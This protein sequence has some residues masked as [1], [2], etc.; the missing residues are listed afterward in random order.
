M[1]ILQTDFQKNTSN[2]PTMLDFLTVINIRGTN[3][4]NDKKNLYKT[5]YD[6]KVGEL[7]VIEYIQT[8]GNPNWIVLRNIWLNH[9]GNSECDLIL[10]T[11]YTIYVIEIK[12]YAGKFTYKNG[13]CYFNENETT[14]NP[15]EQVRKN[16]VNLQNILKQIY[17]NLDIQAVT[18]FAGN[19]NDVEIQSEL[20]DIKVII[21]TQIRSFILQIKNS[22][23]NKIDTLNPQKI[24]QTLNK[25]EISNPFMLDPLT[26]DEMNE[27]RGGIYCANCNNYNVEFSRLF[28]HCKCGLT[29]S[30]E[31]AIIRTIC[32]FGVLTYKRD[33]YRKD[34]IQFVGNKTSES[35]IRRVI[36]KHF[37]MLSNSKYSACKNKRLLYKDLKSQFIVTRQRKVND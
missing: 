15:F 35:Q 32:D 7:R 26:P 2:L 19:D 29:E 14:T 18:I 17:P 36:K 6:G 22:E 27:I 28:V 21:R 16:K 24:I 5:V 33:M 10:I 3:Y 12:N 23:T 13:K 1:Q 34:L 4:F 37:T 9:F 8:Y 11:K 30:R 31:E 25:F 20:H